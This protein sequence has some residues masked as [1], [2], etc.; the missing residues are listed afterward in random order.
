MNIDSYNLDSLRALVRKLEKENQSLKQKLSEA[1]IP[2]D[3]ENIFSETSAENAEYDPDQGGRII[4]R[5]ITEDMAKW[6]FSMFW[7]RNDVYAKRGS[8]GGYFRKRLNLG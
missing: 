1:N 5:Y 6:Y 8:K 7:G 4:E 2:Y 3:S